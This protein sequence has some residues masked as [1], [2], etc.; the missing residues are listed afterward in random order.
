MGHGHGLTTSCQNWKPH[1]L[2]SHPKHRNSTGVGYTLH[3]W[4]HPSKTSDSNDTKKVRLISDQEER[5][6]AWGGISG[7]GVRLI[8]LRKTCKTHLVKKAQQWLFFLRKKKGDQFPCRLLGNFYR[9]TMESILTNC[10][11]M[12]YASCT[13]L[14]R[15]TCS[16]WI[17]TSDSEQN[18]W[19]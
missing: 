2:Y 16:P 3:T 15:R 7:S 9:S 11:T 1:F 5:A 17:Q 4:L 12:W 18:S 19:P 8:F 14:R 6:Q 10:S 13:A